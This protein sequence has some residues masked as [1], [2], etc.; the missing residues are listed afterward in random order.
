MI[1]AQ[2][3]KHNN[4]FGQRGKGECEWPGKIFSEELLPNLSFEG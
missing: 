3:D 2:C 4:Q 1:A